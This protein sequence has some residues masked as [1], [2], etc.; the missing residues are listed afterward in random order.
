MEQL[1]EKEWVLAG[2]QPV[3]DVDEDD[4][5]QDAQVRAAYGPRSW[6]V[7]CGLTFL[8]LFTIETYYAL[9]YGAAPAPEPE[10]PAKVAV[11]HHM[12]RRV[13]AAGSAAT[14]GFAV[15]IPSVPGVLDNVLLGLVS[16]AG[17]LFAPSCD[18]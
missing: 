2:T 7:V 13:A 8:T 18:C 5:P 11:K 6:A 12:A 17:V 3:E 10:A 1:D 15:G 9:G 4:A 16:G 14:L